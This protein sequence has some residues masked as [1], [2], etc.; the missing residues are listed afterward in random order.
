[1]ILAKLTKINLQK[2]FFFHLFT[3]V[4]CKMILAKKKKKRLFH[5]YFMSQMK[6][7]NYLKMDHQNIC[8]FFPSI[9]A[10]QGFNRS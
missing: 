2:P 5:C 9:L 1:M 10:S 4:K 6:K 3:Y 8:Y 7:N